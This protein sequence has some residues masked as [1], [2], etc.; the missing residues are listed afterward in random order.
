MWWNVVAHPC[1]FRRY[2]LFTQFHWV[3]Q[4]RDQDPELRL[5]NHV[6]ELWSC[7]PPLFLGLPEVWYETLIAIFLCLWICLSVCTSA[8]WLTI[9]LYVLLY[10]HFSMFICVYVWLCMCV[11]MYA[12][13]S[14]SLPVWLSVSVCM[15]VCVSI[16][17]CVCVC[18]GVFKCQYR[19][20]K[21][22]SITICGNETV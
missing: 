7:D 10:I 2:F 11:R 14:V 13:L 18:V 19:M 15:P 6:H 12:C 20:T 3:V 16:S 22:R 9:Y 1:E 17:K 4:I 8:V 21:M 5:S